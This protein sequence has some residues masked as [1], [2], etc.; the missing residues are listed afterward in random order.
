M[1]LALHPEVVHAANRAKAARQDRLDRHYVRPGCSGAHLEQDLAGT[2]APFMS[3]EM[4]RA[5]CLPYMKQRVRNVRQFYDRVSLHCCGMSIPLMEMFIE[6]GIGCYQSMQTT[7]GMEV[8]KLKGM[9]GGRMCFWGGV[10]LE[11]LIQG[12]PDDVRKEVRQAMQRGA[13]GGGFILGPSH[14]IAANT[15]YENFM[16]MLDEFVALRDKF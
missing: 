3:P 9:F 6:A 16:A 15:K 2:N 10:S 14:S 1:M 7:A 8:G 4:F 12:G 5:L 13:P 11:V